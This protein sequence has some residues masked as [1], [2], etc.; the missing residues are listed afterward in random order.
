MAVAVNVSP[1]QLARAE[2]VTRVESMLQSTGVLGTQIVFEITESALMSDPDTVLGVLRRLKSLGIR[3]AIDDFG[4]GYSSLGHLKRFPVDSVKIDRTFVRE[5]D[6]NAD[7]Q[8]LVKAIVAMSHSLRLRTV[9][10]G[11]ETVAQASVLRAMGCTALQGFLYAPA[12]PRE[13][14]DQTLLRLI[15]PGTAR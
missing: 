7:D 10:E 2:F 4:T 9:A 8:A 14:L 1:V 15:Y 6:T 3:L 11:V 12:V 5:L 13:N